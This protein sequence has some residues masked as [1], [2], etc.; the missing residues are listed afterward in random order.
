MNKN[1]IISLALLCVFGAG[2]A[3]ATIQQANTSDYNEQVGKKLIF[4]G[5]GSGF[6]VITKFYIKYWNYHN[7][8]Q[9]HEETVLS[10]NTSSYVYSIN[11]SSL[12]NATYVQWEVVIWDSHGNL[13]RS[14]GGFSLIGPTPTPFNISSELE[15]STTALK[16]WLLNNTAFNQKFNN[17]DSSIVSQIDEKISNYNEGLVA[18]LKEI[19]LTPSQI[20]SIMTSIES[21]FSN[22]LAS[23]E[24]QVRDI[25]NAKE[26]GFNN[27]IRTTAIFIFIAIGVLLYSLHYK[28]YIKL[29]AFKSIKRK[30]STTPSNDLDIF[31]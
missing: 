7:T 20:N 17:L 16:D 1:I 18:Q 23:K 4:Y 24:Q 3:S 2:I 9:R 27:G 31:S 21:G 6:D 22:T 29:S 5:D 12:W 26:E 10:L 14:E 11:P 15:N 28:G 8:S 13:T 19:G 30:P 25:L